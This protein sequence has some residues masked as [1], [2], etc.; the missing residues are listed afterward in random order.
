MENNGSQVF[1]R[2][3]YFNTF[4]ENATVMAVPYVSLDFWPF[5]LAFRLPGLGP[6]STGPFDGGVAVQG[7]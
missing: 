2:A 7:A 5:L 6:G 4:L 1:T 3:L